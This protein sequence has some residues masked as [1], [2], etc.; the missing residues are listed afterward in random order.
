MIREQRCIHCAACVPA[1]RE[2][3]IS[4]VGEHLV[5]EMSRCTVCGDCVDVCQ[6]QAREM[7]GRT[8]TVSEVMAEIEK[9]VIFYDQSGGG[10]TF[11]GGEPLMQ[12]EFVLALVRACHAHE[13]KT[14]IDTSGLASWKTLQEIAADLDLI[15]YDIKVMDEE[16]HGKFTGVSNRLILDNLRRLVS[17]GYHV[18]I[19]V[20]LIPG[21]NDDDENISRLG[22]FVASLS[23]P[24]RVS[25]LPYHKAGVNKYARL[26]KAYA[27]P[28]I[29]P[30][31]EARMAELGAVLQSFGLDI[32]IGA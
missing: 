11:S 26:N 16:R 31:S 10:V 27:I 18:A 4:V 2:G 1:C 9:D 3:A 15:L 8:M 25:L 22:E 29:E 13:I 24:P 32:H 5:T 17:E 23:T 20:P 7:I 30:P 19:R 12:P 21:I 14:A 6:T 28:E